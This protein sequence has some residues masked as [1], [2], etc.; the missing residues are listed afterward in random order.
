MKFYRVKWECGQKPFPGRKDFYISNELFTQKEFEKWNVNPEYVEEVR[1]LERD[2]DIFSGVRSCNLLELPRL[3]QFIDTFRLEIW[4]KTRDNISDGQRGNYICFALKSEIHKMLR[5]YNEFELADFV[6][7]YHSKKIVES[8]FPEFVKM[9]E[10]A[11]VPEEGRICAG[12]FGCLSPESKEIR[13][14]VVDEVINQLKS[15]K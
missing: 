13:L 10:K 11:T 15:K 9:E 3:R 12:W 5:E 2:T 8:Y 6:I 1:F 14:S 7:K 4:E